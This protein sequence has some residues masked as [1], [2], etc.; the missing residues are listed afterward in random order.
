MIN[1]H[2]K[3]IAN[4]ISC[5]SIALH[6][7]KN[8]NIKFLPAPINTGIIFKRIDINSINNIVEAKFNSVTATNLGT[9]ITNTEKVSVST[10]EHLMSAIWAS[11]IDNLIIEIDHQEVP[12]M[13]GSASPFLFL[14]Q[15]AGIIIQEDSKK[16]LIINK[17]IEFFE[18]DKFIKAQPS[19]SFQLDLTINFNNPYISCNQLIFD[20]NLHSFK[21]NIAKAR[22]F[23]FANEVEQMH[24]MNLA[25]GGSLNNAIVID[26]NGIVNKE[27]LRYNNE[28][29]KHKALDFIG[30]IFLSGYYVLANFTAH[31]TG[32]T[33]NNK[34]LHHLFQQSDCWHISN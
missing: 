30:D 22:T 15:C 28:F 8:V 31:K 2:Q 33:V 1:S 27:G 16:Y 25:K 19:N 7:G 9:T 6:S 14:L 5:N 21:D 11:N 24:K 20:T 18:Q 10:I 26:D 13:D 32:H 17:P 4:A 23:C 34:F 29:I 12:I 3:T